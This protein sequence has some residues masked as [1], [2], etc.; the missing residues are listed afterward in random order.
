[1][2]RPIFEQPYQPA[3]AAIQ[4]LAPARAAGDAPS[5]EAQT[6]IAHILTCVDTLTALPGARPVPAAEADELRGHIERVIELV[7]PLTG[8][9]GRWDDPVRAENAQV[10]AWVED[11]FRLLTA[12]LDV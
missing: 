4:A 2:A 5:S 10:R 9:S 8:P 6:L 3:R 12:H 1:M 11:A 7:T